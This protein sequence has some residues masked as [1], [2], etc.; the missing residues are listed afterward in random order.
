MVVFQSDFFSTR[1]ADGKM[2]WSD[3]V[4][5]QLLSYQIPGWHHYTFLEEPA[6][7]A[8][9]LRPLLDRVDAERQLPIS[10]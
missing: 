8:E 1:F 5:G 3:L 4:Y 7:I 6:L 10:K 9:R 2:G